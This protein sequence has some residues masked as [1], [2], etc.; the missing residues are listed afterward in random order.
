MIIEQPI[1]ENTTVT[2]KT[3]SGDEVVA[4]YVSEDN[5]TITITK[6]LALV[7]S[8]QGMGLA[9]FAFTVPLDGKLKI[10][11]SAVVFMAKTED[12]MASQYMTSTSG[13]AT[14]NSSSFKI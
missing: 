5:N 1:K 8:Q 12:Q 3:T 14:P 7:A 13:I 6:P 11:K 10:Y 4:R 9:P 2:I